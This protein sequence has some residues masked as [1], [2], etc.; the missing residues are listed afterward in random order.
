MNIIK[1]DFYIGL[2][3]LGVII[4]SGVLR[5]WIIGDYIILEGIQFVDGDIGISDVINTYGSYNCFN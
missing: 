3:E 4:F 1:S 5:V 2:V